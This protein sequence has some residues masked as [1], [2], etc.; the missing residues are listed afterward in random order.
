SQ[1]SE[2]LSGVMHEFDV[3]F[4]LW[5]LSE[6]GALEICTTHGSRVDRGR[7]PRG[8]AV[9]AHEQETAALAYHHGWLWPFRVLLRGAVGPAFALS[10]VT[11]RSGHGS[12]GS[13][14]FHVPLSETLS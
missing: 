1:W 4:W 14:R 11:T 2:E 8:T 12:P 10:D 7:L 13:D 9:A 6:S 3:C 5:R